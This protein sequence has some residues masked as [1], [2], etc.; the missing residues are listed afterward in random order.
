MI[1]S[2]KRFWRWTKRGVWVLLGFWAVVC[3]LWVAF[4]PPVLD[5]IVTRKLT[6]AG[7]A[8]F[9]LDVD[10][11]T[12]SQAHL[13]FRLSPPPG[14][15]AE[16][17]DGC[18]HI[19]A[20]YSL[21]GL[22]TGRVRQLHL[23]GL[24]VEASYADGRLRMDHWGSL[25]T[26]GGAF[27]IGQLIIESSELRVKQGAAQV[28]IPFDAR[29]QFSADGGL[30]C[31]ADV[32]LSGYL[33][34]VNAA[35]RFEGRS[36]LVN[37]L[38]A[39]AHPVAAVLGASTPMAPFDVSVA[40]GQKP[41]ELRFDMEDRRLSVRGL[42]I[43][44]V[45][46]ASPAAGAEIGAISLKAAVDFA[47][48][49]DGLKLAL[50]EP[51]RGRL[52]PAAGGPGQ[53]P[54]RSV[55]IEWEVG[56][57]TAEIPLATSGPMQPKEGAIRV[58]GIAC[59]GH[60]LPPIT[61]R[62]SM[63]R[64][65]PVMRLDWPLVPSALVSA[66][67]R[68]EAGRI[69]ASAVMAAAPLRELQELVGG[70]LGLGTTELGGKMDLQADAQWKPDGFDS[71]VTLALAD[72]SY[73]N[74]E[75]QMKIE[76]VAG[77]IHLDRLWPIHSPA[78]Q[79]VHIERYEQGRIVLTEGLIRL[80]I[81]DSDHLIIERTDWSFGSG[82]RV[83][84]H[85]IQYDRHHPL[86]D[87]ELFVEDLNLEDWLSVLTNEKVTAS[88]RLYGRVPFKA[89]PTEDGYKIAFGEGFLYST[90][91][92]GTLRFADARK[93]SGLLSTA[94]PRFEKDP[95]LRAVRERLAGALTDFE[96]SMFRF[97][98]IPRESGE[99][100]L[101]MQTQGKGRGERGQEIGSLTVNINNFQLAAN[102]ALFG[103]K[104]FG[105]GVN[106][107]L[108][109]FFRPVERPRTREAQP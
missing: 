14:V 21:R 6:E 26:T 17:R 36:L 47:V 42:S 108:E 100:A 29:V 28:R 3:T 95:E 15:Q 52:D 68:S 61:G 82:G 93:V 2:M 49:A 35:G 38:K 80:Q 8:H 12:P 98:L 37:Q 67:L 5:W 83:T 106:R 77:K 41:A 78:G 62:S 9:E 79:E 22:L 76:G 30:I 97:N 96:Y 71:A 51:L 54:S 7:I 81:E 64:A 104:V 43:E 92:K 103:Q 45:R 99:V 34:Q 60:P 89:R 72:A 24:V 63:T 20:F 75:S 59:D 31:G 88:G 69:N 1:G 105:E 25:R 27:P 39:R 85:G 40:L 87:T 70:F 109:E 65:G 11:V 55:P 90:P 66:E 50:S 4:L 13:R 44:A 48:S 18:E 74:A 84:A 101:Q 16:Y 23:S 73:R 57:L 53:R 56:H 33:A 19:H 102:M 91:G 107:R 32:Q 86:I 58:E 46:P 94:D 10:W